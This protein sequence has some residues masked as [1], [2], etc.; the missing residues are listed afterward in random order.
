MKWSGVITDL[1]HQNLNLH[2]NLDDDVKQSPSPILD[3]PIEIWEMILDF[4]SIRDVIS[5]KFLSQRFYRLSFLKKQLNYLIEK[6][7]KIFDVNEYHSMFSYFFMI[8]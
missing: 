6:S 4:V 2:I 5:F 3:L 1:I 8:Y 7:C